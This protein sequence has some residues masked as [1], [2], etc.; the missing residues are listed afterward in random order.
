MGAAV[1][2]PRQKTGLD[3]E[4]AVATWLT[5]RGWT[6]VATRF[7]RPVGE[8]D[9]VAIDPGRVLVGVEV[10]A[11]HTNRTGSP[12]ESVDRR[13]IRRMRATLVAFVA[14]LPAGALRA[15]GLRIDLAAVLPEPGGWRIR[16]LQGID[17]W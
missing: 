10:K 9:L 11:R 1:T 2:A 4:R 3:A 8:L 5:D 7:R 6:V 15:S 16:L 14:E 17:G 12:V 13:R